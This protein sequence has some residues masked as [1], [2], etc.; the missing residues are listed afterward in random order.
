[1]K[2]LF[3]SICVLVGLGLF[4]ARRKNW[5][6]S[7]IFKDLVGIAAIISMLCA[8][9]VLLFVRSSKESTHRLSVSSLSNTIVGET[10]AILSGETF[11]DG[12]DPNL[13]VWFQYGETPRYGLESTHYLMYGIGHFTALIR[14]LEPCTKYYYRAVS[15]NTGGTTYGKSYNFITN[16]P[17]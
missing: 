17:P 12:G 7:G 10:E 3:F 1:M 4:F 2:L 11:D 6:S 16:C 14:N 15:R 8:I 9:A 13:E 5:I